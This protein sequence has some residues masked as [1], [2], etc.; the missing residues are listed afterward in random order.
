[1]NNLIDSGLNLRTIEVRQLHK[2]VEDLNYN[3]KQV[4]HL[5][6][7]KGLTG[8]D[9]LSITGSKG[10]RGSVWAFAEPSRFINVYSNIQ[11]SG[12]ITLSFING[13]VTNDLASLLLVLDLTEFVQNDIIVLPSRDILQFNSSTSQFI[14][15]GIRFAD[16]LS[17]T[18][19]EVIKIVNNILGGLTN[20]DVFT[21]YKGIVKN[22]ADNS[23]GLNTELNL[24]SVV[25]VPVSN[26]G[27][28]LESSTFQFTSLKEAVTTTA[29]QNMLLTG[30]PSDY[31]ILAQ[32]TMSTK[33]VDFMAG[34]DDFGAL[35]VMQNSYKNGIIIGHT[36]S[37][38]FSTWGRIYRTED[39]L[40]FLS[41]YDPTLDKVARLDLGKNGT[42]LYSPKDLKILVKT[43]FISIE[44][45]TTNLKY[46]YATENS[47][48]IGN[49][50]LPFTSLRQKDYL[51][52]YSKIGTTTNIL[53][54]YGNE[55]KES[56]FQPKDD[57]IVNESRFLATH[58]LLFGLQTTVTNAINDFSTRIGV[59]ESQEV[60]RKQTFHGGNVNM[61]TL[62]EFGVHLIKRKIDGTYSNFPNDFLRDGFVTEALV[63]VN[64]F[65]NADEIYIEQIYIHQSIKSSNTTYVTSKRKGKSTN[66]GNSFVWGQWNYILDSKNFKINGGNKIVTDEFF[67]E[68]FELKVNHEEHSLTE[69]LA[70]PS[71][72]TTH[73]VLK[74]LELDNWGHPTKEIGQNLDEWYYTK[75]E[76]DGLIRVGMPLGAI[77]MWEGS[78]NDIPNG[79]ELHTESKGKF[80]VSYDSENTDYSQTKNTGGKNFKKLN[81]NNLPPHLHTGTTNND[82][83]HRH[84][85]DNDQAGGDGGSGWLVSGGTQRG[86]NQSLANAY[87]KVDG[88]HTHTFTTNQ[89]GNGDAFD[90]RPE[91][92]VMAL[93]KF[94]GLGIPV[95][96]N[97][98]D[99]YTA[100]VGV[101]FS[102]QITSVGRVNSWRAVGLPSGLTI[103]TS[104]GL[105][106]GTPISPIDTTVRIFAT[107]T[108]GESL[109]YE[110]NFEVGASTGSAPVITSNS[111]IDFLIGSDAS[112]QITA[113]G[114][115][116]SYAVQGLPSFLSVDSQTGIISGTVPQNTTP[117]SNIITISVTNGNG[118]TTQTVRFNLASINGGVQAPT[119]L[120]PGTKTEIVGRTF[121]IHTNTG[122]QA[123]SWSIDGLPQSLSFNTTNG[124]V[125]GATTIEDKGSYNVTVSATN[126]VG[127]STVEYVL[128]IKVG[129]ELIK[130]T[131]I[132]ISP[133]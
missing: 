131:D 35:A 89:T 28:G 130:N 107:N 70:Q 26:A 53:G 64:R 13:Q 84:G 112:F 90:N 126:S 19:T 87:T 29:M 105:I 30:S 116:T 23:L 120:F 117:L 40:R 41:D 47:V 77:I 12:Q 128:I 56:N 50:V 63:K 10:E 123:S 124:Q 99:R 76:V 7:F 78:A 102:V 66:G 5:P 125:V 21:T 88:S 38:D 113:S 73:N 104:D 80:I 1:M 115:P 14:D 20:N 129:T 79:F 95:I 52:L 45:Y 71:T 16:G 61:N 8:K 133:V 108:E 93:I 32:K 6:G 11:S 81:V 33:T 83:S 59:L 75:E 106:S 54:L 114:N 68:N 110:V 92:Y 25:D 57:V 111:Q 4:L 86:D 127:T 24:N 49:N 109:P 82:G 97:T 85:F 103:N 27:S 74:G 48:E 100:T 22:Y 51:K 37:N 58:N 44:D 118:T 18:E 122:G 91:Y 43:G 94:V 121:Y 98:T 3:F 96:S 65:T 67:G 17:L 46:F 119:I 42:E 9:G 132:S 69:I 101:P 62:V 31:H 36:K 60:Y 2:I 15:T 39:K 34:V 72:A 55:I